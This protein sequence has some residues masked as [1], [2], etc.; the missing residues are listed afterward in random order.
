MHLKG[1]SGVA[2]QVDVT[3]PH[4]II[5]TAVE[6]GGTQAVED[7]RQPMPPAIAWLLGG[8]GAD[9][10]YIYMRHTTPWHVILAMTSVCW[11]VGPAILL[12]T[13]PLAYGYWHLLFL[14]L[15]LCGSVVCPVALLISLRV[16][17]ED[18]VLNSAAGPLSL[19]AVSI[20]AIACIGPLVE[21]NG[22]QTPFG[23]A[24]LFLASL[25]IMNL[26]VVRFPS[27]VN[28]ACAAPL[29]AMPKCRAMLASQFS[30]FINCLSTSC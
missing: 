7:S 12:L 23:N 17:P 14:P 6:E 21:A 15:D 18:T 4:A 8:L 16:T 9:P 27:W 2:V 29:C 22:T 11:A 24:A 26:I 13:S 25:F 28:A 19:L 10:K 30:W 3:D 5:G 20:Y 1:A